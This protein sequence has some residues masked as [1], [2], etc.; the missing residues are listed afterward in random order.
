M[1]FESHL[2]QALI[3]WLQEQGYAYANGVTI[4][5]GGLGFVNNFVLM[6]CPSC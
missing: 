5:P 2:E 6:T 4:S 3:E 1:V